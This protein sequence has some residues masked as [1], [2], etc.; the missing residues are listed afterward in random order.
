MSKQKRN[1][2]EITQLEEVR[3]TQKINY[4]NTKTPDNQEI[5]QMGKGAVNGTESVT[6]NC[7]FSNN[8]VVYANVQ[9]R[10]RVDGYHTKVIDNIEVR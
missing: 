6:K 10:G 2:T 5:L 8:A 7:K 4:R 9:I 3:R 1:Y